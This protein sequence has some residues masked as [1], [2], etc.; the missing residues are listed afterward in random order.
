MRL[1]HRLLLSFLPVTIFSLLLLGALVQQVAK[2]NMTD[3]LERKL[4]ANAR[5][6]Q[7][8]IKDYLSFV[9]ERVSAFNSRLLIRKMLANNPDGHVSKQQALQLHNILMSTQQLIDSFEQ[10][11]LISKNHIVVASTNEQDVGKPFAD[12]PLLLLLKQ[13]PI[14]ARTEFNQNNELRLV[15]GIN[16]VLDDQ[17][18]GYLV[19]KN[20]AQQIASLAQQRIGLGDTGEAYLIKPSLTSPNKTVYLSQLRFGETS[21][22]LTDPLASTAFELGYQGIIHSIDY[23][24]QE[25]LAVTRLF[26]EFGWALIVKID[27]EEAFAPLYQLNFVFFA[28]AAGCLLLVTLVSIWLAGTIASPLEKMAQTALCIERGELNK[29]FK[30]SR[31]QEVDFLAR[32]FNQ[33]LA[34]IKEHNCKL[35]ALVKQRTLALEQNNQTL[36]QSL[37]QLKQAQSQLVESEKMAALGGLVAGIAHEVNTP[38]GAALGA[39]SHLRDLVTKVNQNYKNGKLTEQAFERLLSNAD[40]AMTIVVA[41]LERGA[42]L[43]RSFKRV[44]VDQSN[45]QVLLFNL[46]DYVA[47]VLNSLK[48]QYKHQPLDI[49]FEEH[50][51]IIIEQAPGLIA[52]LVTNLVLNAVSHAFSAES[53]GRIEIRLSQRQQQIQLSIEDNGRG[54]TPEVCQRIFEPFYTTK[55]GSGGSGLGLHI[56]YN[57]VTQKLQGHINVT[58]K[59]S[60]GTRFDITFPA[61]IKATDKAKID[62]LDM[63]AC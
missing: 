5:I 47:D 46:T 24:G 57:I 60:E 36:N 50:H 55:R 42:E 12:D 59:P 61:K 3:L 37:E 40:S 39:S 28:T 63:N 18:V 4:D 35:E 22:Q 25:V 7:A 58:S 54:M 20:T 41:N 26:D 30:R 16:L 56:V 33:M 17:V 52:Q 31:L 32:I 53:K 43:I 23:R 48:P 15:H 13:G 6:Q 19:V 44:A 38:I 14:T 49:V 2:S 27:V 62:W 8:R 9:E 21:D 10:I 51:N 34:T 29:V 11:Y 1:F 45:E